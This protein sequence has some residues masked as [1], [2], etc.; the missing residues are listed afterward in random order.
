M[1]SEDRLKREQNEGERTG[2]EA[3][4]HREG[5]DV[6]VRARRRWR[7]VGDVEVQRTARGGGT[8]DHIVEVTLVVPRA[9]AGVE[10]GEDSVVVLHVCSARPE[11]VHGGS[12][13]SIQIGRAS[14][15]ERV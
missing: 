7:R 2:M 11:T 3:V 13:S 12:S 5:L 14:C 15:R 1:P 4:A 6:V 9:V 10:E 8:E